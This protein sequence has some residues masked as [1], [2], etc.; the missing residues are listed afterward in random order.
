MTDPESDRA[1]KNGSNAV[2]VNS[3]YVF[4]HSEKS[5]K[6][7]DFVSKKNRKIV[8]NNIFSQNL[9]LTDPESDRAR[10]N[11]SIPASVNSPSAFGHSEKNEKDSGILSTKN[12]NFS[13]TNFE[14]FGVPERSWRIDGYGNRSDFSCSIRFWIRQFKILTKN[15]FSNNFSICF[16]KCFVNRL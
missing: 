8:R 9:E 6:N 2:S 12:D 15:N 16:R 7:L 10:K 5:N 1:R 14:F 3:P 13:G 4:R 11:G